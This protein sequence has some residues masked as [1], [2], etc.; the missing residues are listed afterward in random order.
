M[1][2]NTTRY[3]LRQDVAKPCVYQ[4]SFGASRP[5]PSEAEPK[6]SAD[7][8]LE[9]ICGK[10]QRS[11]RVEFLVK[12]QNANGSSWEPARVIDKDAINE[13]EEKRRRRQ[14]LQSKLQA[15]KEEQDL[16]ATM[17][18]Q[19]HRILAHRRFEGEKRY[20]VQ[21]VGQSAASVSW[22][23]GK[24]ISNAL[25]QEFELAVRTFQTTLHPAQPC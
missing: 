6:L 19:V 5:S 18:R 16:E 25:V 8:Q 12:W 2:E 3:P 1:A 4:P 23:G 9:R 24:A 10:R 7:R 14:L 20:L 15:E 21:W 13:Y 17:E 22:E 11:G